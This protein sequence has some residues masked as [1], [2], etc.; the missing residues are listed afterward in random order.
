MSSNENEVAVAMS[1]ATQAW[2]ESLTPT[3]LAHAQYGSPLAPDAEAERVQWFYTP[4]D[5]GGLALREQSPRQ[6]SLAMQLLA[7]GL[8]ESGY[9]TVATVMGLENILDQVEGWNVHWGRERG[10]DPELYWLR[11]FGKPG[12]TVWGWRMGGHHISINNLIARGRVVATTPNFL[13]A[14]PA[15]TTLLGSSLRPLMGLE[16]L[17]RRLARSLDPAQ[18][19]HA[20]LHSS[21][22]SDIVSGNRSRVAHGDTMMHMQ[23]LWRG[24]FTDPELIALVDEVDRRAEAASGYTGSDHMTMAITAPPK[25]VGASRLDQ[26]QRDELRRLISLYTG[27]A[28]KPIADRHTAY[29]SRD[30]TLDEVHFGW[31]GS[32]DF[33][34]PHYYRIQGPRLLIEYDNTQRHANHAHSVWRDPVGDFGLD[35]LAEHRHHSAH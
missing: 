16:E 22:I 12:G 17:A 24:R 2:L 21:A 9:A 28:P 26:R 4:T 30:S 15:T 20:R 29:Y 7:T 1:A 11:V 13:G 25:G 8:S 27:R 33:G 3:Q 18:W 23:D 5:H 19:E 32:I 14:D 35:S 31:A 34:K 10:R 6:Q